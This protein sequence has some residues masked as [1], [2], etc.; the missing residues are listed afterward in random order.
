MTPAIDT[1]IQRTIDL[2]HMP[3]PTGAEQAR[4]TVVRNWWIEDGHRDV[5]DDEVGNVWACARDGNGPAVV[6]CAHLDTVF[7]SDID[8]D[9][10]RDGDRLHGPSVGDDS[11]GL[12]ALSAAASGIG[13]GSVP[14]W[15]LATVGEEGLGN[16]RGVTAALDARGAD[17]GAFIA[18]EGNYLGRVST[19]GVGSIR[20]RV[21]V[22][23]PGGHAWEAAD[24]P[25]AVH[26]AAG[27]IAR[28]GALPRT[29]GTS[30][31]VGRVGGGEGIN[32]RAR[33][34]WFEL[35]LRADDP[36][37]LAAL[38]ATMDGILTGIE[39]PLA[40]EQVDLGSRPAGSVDPGHALV[41]AANAALEDAGVAITHPST[42]TDAN[43]AHARGIAAIAVGVTTGSGEHTP[44]EWIDL[45]PLEQGI[46]VLTATVDR[47]G[48]A[49]S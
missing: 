5:R 44:Q 22:R 35:D 29:I 34:A 25:S 14:V 48:E 39:A 15:L 38:G 27:A 24:A 19:V 17:V 30:V 7:A 13:S 47:Y 33:E 12:A 46:R 10:Q 16:L 42:S 45:A 2:A 18:V 11:V 26:A 4:A 21:H 6:L 20:R 8:H 43:A 40:V 49:T 32:M 36:G 37:A 23:G 1:V 3:A 41:V 9:V 31:N 28:I